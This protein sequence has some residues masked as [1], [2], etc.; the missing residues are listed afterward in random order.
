MPSVL[1]A[2]LCI[3]VIAAGVWAAAGLLLLRARVRA[4]GSRQPFAAAAGDPAAGI[5]YAFTGAMSP[6]AKESVR[7]HLPS[8][9][10]GLA[11]HGG[12]FTAFAL[13]ALRLAEFGVPRSL[14]LGAR[15][16]LVLGVV[17][18]LG[19]LLKRLLKAELRGLSRPDDVVSNLLATGFVALALIPGPAWLV[20]A[21]LLLVYTPL[22]KIR[23][24]LFFF[25]AR[26]HF[27]AFFGRRGVF[28]PGDSHVH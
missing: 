23:H 27:G 25:V 10:L 28:P 8:Y 14:W 12:I 19:L 16:L 6:G 2:P 15:A 21:I 24:C 4:F 1:S 18:G 9:G 13:L 20:S 17:G 11:F 3:A 26:S 5:R 7:E 22:G